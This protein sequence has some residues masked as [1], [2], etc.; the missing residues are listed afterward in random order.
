MQTPN[1]TVFSY[2]NGILRKRVHYPYNP[3][4]FNRQTAG[5]TGRESRGGYAF[6]I[7]EK[8]NPRK[9]FLEID[10]NN[11]GPKRRIEIDYSDVRL[12]QETKL[13]AV[14]FKIVNAA[15]SQ[16]GIPITGDDGKGT[17]TD[18]D[19]SD[20]SEEEGVIAY[21]IYGTV[22]LSNIAVEKIGEIT[23][24]RPDKPLYIRP[25]YE[26]A[27]IDPSKAATN[28]INKIYLT[29]TDGRRLNADS[30]LIVDWDNLVQAITLYVYKDSVGA[31]VPPSPVFINA[32]LRLPFDGGGGGS[33]DE[34]SG[35][36]SAAGQITKLTCKVD[37]SSTSAGDDTSSDDEP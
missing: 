27:N 4:L 5:E 34:G 17:A 16:N 19:I 21:E 36:A 30:G 25:Y 9:A 6:L 31:I 24:K 11:N 32:E 1:D 15:V 20:P 33:E 12:R 29:D 13:T 37:F 2:N 22:D 18:Y 26:P 35:E 28:M 3:N 10:Y 8:A 7:S 14:G 23:E